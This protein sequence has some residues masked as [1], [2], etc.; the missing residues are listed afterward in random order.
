MKC[1][2]V[3]ITSYI[4]A[5]VIIITS[6]LS[7]PF[8]V[9]AQTTTDDNGNNIIKVLDMA[10]N[11]TGIVASPTTIQDFFDYMQDTVTSG[12]QAWSDIVDTAY[13]NVSSFVSACKDKVSDSSSGFS[14]IAGSLIN[15]YLEHLDNHTHN[16]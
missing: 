14:S 6:V 1:M 4:M 13:D 8:S 15:G 16:A 9:S 12:A 7:L 3:N 11:K 5:V 10:L 2:C